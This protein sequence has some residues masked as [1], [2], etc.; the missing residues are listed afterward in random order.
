M[1]K[2]IK[3]NLGFKNNL[4]FILIALII[5]FVGFV[6][7]R[8][9]Q[10][11]KNLIS[12]M[13]IPVILGIIYENRRLSVSW[14]ELTLKLAL[15]LFISLI[16]FIPDKKEFDYGLDHHIELY[17]YFFIVIFTLISVINHGEKLIP[18]LTEGASLLLS[19]SIIYWIVDI[20]FLNFDDAFSFGLVIIGLVFC[21]LTFIHAFS[22]VK[23]TRTARLFL[24]IWSSIIMII[25]AVDYIYRV[26]NLDYFV[27]NQFLNSGLNTL[28]YFLLGVSLIYIFQNAFMLLEYVPSKHRF[29]G[30]EHMKD[31]RKMNKTHIKRFSMVQVK[32]SDSFIVLGIVSLVYFI[33][34]RFQLMPRH[35]MIWLVLWLYPIVFLLRS[36]L[37]KIKIVS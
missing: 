37:L 10:N 15:S 11:E 2:K 35:T 9:F 18:K 33:N 20:G 31:I 27:E 19:I 6:F 17:L 3:E 7:Y 29:Y 1:I 23:L 12:I 21:I 14:G 36:W 5:L 24:S 32:I 28:Q 22:Y 13:L 34:F 8:I 25:F 26:F 30:K 4:L 16:A